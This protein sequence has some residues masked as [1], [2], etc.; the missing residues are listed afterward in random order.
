MIRLGQG[1]GPEDPPNRPNPIDPRRNRWVT[2]GWYGAGMDVMGE[3]DGV[4]SV[5]GCAAVMHRWELPEHERACA[6]VLIGGVL[7]VDLAGGGSGSVDVGDCTG[8][9]GTGWTW[10]LMRRSRCT[11]CSGSGVAPQLGG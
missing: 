11:V 3:R 5:P 4:C 8:C 9:E 7:K 2:V 6:K 1:R 10:R